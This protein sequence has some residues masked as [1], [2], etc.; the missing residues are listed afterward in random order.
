MVPRPAVDRHIQAKAVL[1]ERDDVIDDVLT[2]EER[3]LC[4]CR[5][6]RTVLWANKHAA[7]S[8]QRHSGPHLARR[9][10]SGIYT[11]KAAQDPT[12]ASCMIMCN[13]QGPLL[14]RHDVVAEGVSANHSHVVSTYL[15]RGTQTACLGWMSLPRHQ[16]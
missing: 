1:Q 15:L 2:F 9:T 11:A 13:K 4:A 12:G 5:Q 6:V 7:F 3:V 14:S 10:K 16:V 8:L